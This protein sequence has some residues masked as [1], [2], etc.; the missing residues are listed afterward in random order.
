[1]VQILRKDYDYIM[2]NSPPL[3]LTTDAK[4]I[5]QLADV[6]ILVVEAEEVKEKDLFKAVG[7]LEK[8]GVKV[9]SV[10]LNRIRSSRGKNYK[11]KIKNH[12]KLVEAKETRR[13]NGTHG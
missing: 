3:M 9:V 12:Y 8:I 5:S 2:V 7:M 6:T 10:V 11:S 13:H 1:M 4:F